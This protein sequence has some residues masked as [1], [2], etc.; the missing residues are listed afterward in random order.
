MPQDFV[1][2]HTLKTQLEANLAYSAL[3]AHGLEVKLQA[4]RMA[5]FKDAGVFNILV[6]KADLEDARTILKPEDDFVDMDEYVDPDDD[7]YPRCPKCNS[8]NIETVPLER[9]LKKL[10]LLT[11]GFALLFMRRNWECRKCGQEWRK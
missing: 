2:V 7:T 5:R 4:Y 6:R 11:L 8:V 3:E 9:D 10:V 1:V